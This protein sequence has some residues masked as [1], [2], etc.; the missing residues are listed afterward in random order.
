[1]VRSESAVELELS[2]ESSKEIL[3][4]LRKN[5]VNLT[6]TVHKI[7]NHGEEIIT[8]LHQKISR[9][10][11]FFSEE[12]LE[13]VIR[14]LRKI[15]AKNSRLADRASNNYDCFIYLFFFSK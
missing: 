2:N 12:P 3:D 5:Q 13:G 6:P 11:G 1:M 15:R 4:Y 8:F 9:G 14:K 10:P 7:L